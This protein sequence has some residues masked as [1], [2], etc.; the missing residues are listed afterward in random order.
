MIIRLFNMLNI[1]QC[2]SIE[3][4]QMAL[5]II[6]RE[7]SIE[8]I[9]LVSSGNQV[10]ASFRITD[11]CDIVVSYLRDRFIIILNWLVTFNSS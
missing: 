8:K 10:L 9:Y 4:D 6:C 2:V 7:I 1:F 11:R 3:K 5:K